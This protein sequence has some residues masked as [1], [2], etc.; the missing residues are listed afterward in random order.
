M[1]LKSAF[2]RIGGLFM[3]YLEICEKIKPILKNSSDLEKSSNKY[4]IV[5][6]HRIYTQ[7][8][9]KTVN[10]LE[11]EKIRPHEFFLKKDEIFPQ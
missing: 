4:V 9:I 11:N 3:I 8:E 6:F 5:F 7:K 1:A 10:S 2:S